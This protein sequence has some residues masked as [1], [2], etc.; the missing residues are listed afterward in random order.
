[1]KR[2]FALPA[3]AAMLLFSSALTAQ[4]EVVWDL[5]GCGGSFATRG[6]Y[7]ASTNTQYNHT[8]PNQGSGFQTGMCATQTTSSFLPGAIFQKAAGLVQL[9]V[10]EGYAAI[11]FD[12]Q[13]AGTRDLSGFKG[14]RVSYSMVKKYPPGFEDEEVFVNIQLKSAGGLGDNEFGMP[15]P[16]GTNLTR[17]FLF[18]A[19]KQE[20]G[21]GTIGDLQTVI[22]NSKGLAF[23]VTPFGVVDL[24][25]TKIELLERTINPPPPSNGVMWSVYEDDGCIEEQ[26]GWYG[27]ADINATPLPG[28]SK[29]FVTGF[30]S[31]EVD[32]IKMC[33]AGGSVQ[34]DMLTN[35]VSAGIWGGV[36]FDW[37]PDNAVLDISGE[38]AFYITYSLPS[39]AA[40]VRVQL[41]SDQDGEQF[42]ASMPTGSM[43]R[44]RFPL[45]T[46]TFTKLPGNGPISLNYA[47]Q[48]CIGLQFHANAAGAANLTIEKIE[49]G[50]TVIDLSGA[51]IFLSKESFVFN[52]EQQIPEVTVTMDE[53]LDPDVDYTVTVT[54]AAA[55][56]IGTY[57]I[58]V[59]GSTKGSYTGTK[60]ATYTIT[61]MPGAEVENPTINGDPTGSSITINAVTAP[62]NGQV[63]EY[64]ISTDDTP[65]AAGWQITLTFSNLNPE[66]E[67]YIFARARENSSYFAGPPVSMTSATVSVLVKDRIIP[68]NNPDGQ[69]LELQSVTV[70]AGEFTAGPNPAV[71]S[72]GRVDFF[73]Q[74]REIQNTA[75]Y[76]Y[77][78]SGNRVAKVKI[79]DKTTGKSERRSVGFWD[80]TDSKGRTVGEGTYVVKGKIKAKGGKEERISLVLGVR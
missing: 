72:N 73:W 20:P 44:R 3:M 50:S 48:N 69:A 67:Y 18:D 71:K 19:F 38:E 77:S 10:Y 23:H 54:P 28:R 74:G 53:V 24:T 21:W 32:G 65:P 61:K 22:K 26:N 37:L 36:G 35:T 34:F 5:S 55:T 42:T 31:D 27:Y 63:V 17:T 57:T 2:F 46:A 68:G 66:T 30:P 80:L 56:A 29:V 12:W 41:K 60:T 64:A 58:T 62:E 40:N 52:G 7:S 45:T 51:E 43:Q 33:E 14:V 59:T 8:I 1:M 70:T 15:V 4:D 9:T 78:A 16:S 49:W 39:N 75:L 11:G 13:A 79:S 6:W 25:V 47:L 76:I